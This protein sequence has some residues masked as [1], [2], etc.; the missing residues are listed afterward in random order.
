MLDEG[1][2]MIEISDLQAGRAGEYLVC[3]DLILKGYTAFIAESVLAYDVIVDIDGRLI[4]VQVKT[5]REP[6]AIPQRKDYTPAHLFN[7]RRM[8]RDGRGSYTS[9]DVDVFALVALDT[10]TIGYL[11]EARAKQTMIFRIRDFEGMYFDE[12]KSERR[13][14]ILEYRQMGWSYGAIAKALQM[15]KSQVH[16]IDKG[17]GTRSGGSYLDDYTIE[18]ALKAHGIN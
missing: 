13:T 16:R 17:E 7:I 1:D 15:D 18:D 14:K 2:T 6:K 5:T 3:A 11:P 4:R 8:G 10:R 9:Q 12:L